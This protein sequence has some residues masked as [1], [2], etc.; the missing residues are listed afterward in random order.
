MPGTRFSNI[1]WATRALYTEA[2]GF[3]FDYPIEVCTEAGRRGELRYY[4]YSDRLFLNDLDFDG[5]GV[6]MKRYR[7]LGSQYNPLF[8]AWWGLTNLQRYVRDGA[9]EGVD[10]FL[11]QARWLKN[12]ARTR[13]D[14]AIVWPCYFDWQEGLCRLHAPWIS[15]MYQ[16]VAISTLVRAYRLTGDEEFLSL[17]QRATRVFQ[18]GIEDGGVRTLEN[19]RVLYEE[20]PGY[21]LP[22]VLD[23]FLFS[24][25]GLYDLHVETDDPDVCTL[26][27]DG[28][29]GL[30]QTLPFWDYRGKWS[31]YGSHGYL[32][33]PH[34]HTLNRI[35]L[36]VLGR[37]TGDTDFIRQ[38][39]RWAPENLSW[40]DKLE[41]YT[42]FLAT[43]NRARVRLP[44]H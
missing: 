38:A 8:V 36:L 24:L 32:C 19:G 9:Q 13:D 44:R 39:E 1:Y 15:A 33:P 25:L 23:G 27:T 11:I 22:R 40:R 2:A 3:R 17:S 5:R 43:K 35:L 16:A 6:P 4:I 20:Y 28:I 26:F 29:N 18:K 41:I 30:R 21:P 7:R 14:G 10:R 37:L 31:W 42:V 34:Y 12:A